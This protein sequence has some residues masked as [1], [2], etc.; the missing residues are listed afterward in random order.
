MFCAFIDLLGTK[1]KSKDFE[2]MIERYNLYRNLFKFSKSEID[3]INK[4]I[5]RILK[6]KEDH[7]AIMYDNTE[8]DCYIFSDSIILFST[9]GYDLLMKIATASAHLNENQILFRGGIGYGRT[10][11]DHSDKNDGIVSEALN[12]AALIES[13]IS[14]YPR[15]VLSDD[16]LKKIVEQ[17]KNSIFGIGH[18]LIQDEDSKWFINP[19]FLLDANACIRLSKFINQKIEEYQNEPFLDKY[20]WFGD[21]INLFMFNYEK[22]NYYKTYKISNDSLVNTKKFF[23]GEMWDKKLFFYQQKN[24]RFA[25]YN[26]VK[27]IYFSTFK[28]NVSRLDFSGQMYAFKKDL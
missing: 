12:Q 14:K 15:V 18:Y 28:K 21:L 5:T 19:L 27:K 26:I 17:N 10:Y 3:V 16:A 13:K 23:D 4:E 22:D 2:K 11:I 1:E 7:S 9:D 8:E 24:I 6:E 25:K 20:L